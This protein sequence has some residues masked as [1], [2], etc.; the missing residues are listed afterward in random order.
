MD[1]RST[2][3]APDADLPP[4]E[5]HLEEAEAEADAESDD[6][7][8][9]KAVPAWI[10]SIVMHAVVLASLAAIIIA[11]QPEKDEAPIQ[12]TSLPPPPPEEQ[13]KLEREVK[14]NEVT[15]EVEVESEVPS[16]VSELDVPVEE[17]NKEE[18]IESEVPKGRE[19]ATADSEMGGSGAFMAIGAGGGSAGMF[20]SRSGGGK[21][22]A[23]GQFG[24][25]RASES[26]V[27]A[28]L[29]WFKRHQGPQGEWHVSAYVANCTENPK[30]EPGTPEH[31]NAEQST[32][33]L[34]GYAVLCF[35]GAGY[36]H[37]MP[38]KYKATVKAGLDWL[39]VQQKA[40]GLFGDRN[41]EHAVAT[42]AIAEA[43]AMT[44]D[45]A[46][47]EPAQKAVDVLKERQ[48]KD[49]AYGLGWD[50][51]KA[52]DRHDSSVTGWC[53]MALKSA[54]A[55][56]LDIGETMTGGKVWLERAWK[57][58][59]PGWEKLDPYTGIS[60]F[61]Y[62]WRAKD[63]SF[64]HTFNSPNL[65]R[66]LGRDC[67]A[68]GGLCAVFL[69]YKAGDILL[70]T[71]GNHIMK[72]QV[73]KGFPTNTYYLYYNTLGIFQL[74]GDRWQTWNGTVR[75]LLVNSQRRGDGCFDGSWDFTAK[76]FP[77]AGNGRI[78]ST[79]YCCL[80]LEVYY[81][82]APVAGKKK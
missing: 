52:T 6:N 54:A 78:L 61:P 31:C 12:V 3:P 9:R 16:P 65:T 39:V 63:N 17:F 41:Y 1:L 22:R 44:N 43:Y 21:K 47:R 11:T 30:C 46:L 25:N 40:D 13:P 5:D 18:E 26:A 37:R 32:I 8:V 48:N 60:D 45:P 77:G 20:G 75:D 79:A 23:L 10:I 27:D 4:E 2:P 76:D 58:C 35:L 51:T 50:Y 62:V 70:E 24:G 33:A 71:L 42:M 34:S 38:S 68:I 7:E 80:S 49:D 72:H 14:P 29:R 64:E 19:E 28:A 67:A 55:G 56:G 66:G 81:R 69:G 53:L 82:Y 74:G 73:P 59:N 36:D 57:S 15:L